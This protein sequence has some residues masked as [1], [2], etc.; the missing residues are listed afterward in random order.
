MF[1]AVE[2]RFVFFQLGGVAALDA[3]GSAFFGGSVAAGER[4][5]SVGSHGVQVSIMKESLCER[6]RCSR[7]QFRTAERCPDIFVEEW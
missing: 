2:E 5:S 6:T 7:G 4:G 3:A 1:V